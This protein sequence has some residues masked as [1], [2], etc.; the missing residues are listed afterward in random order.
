VAEAAIWEAGAPPLLLPPPP[1][2][3]PIPAAAPR[4]SGVYSAGPLQYLSAATA[5]ERAAALGL[6]DGAAAAEPFGFDMTSVGEG[7]DL[8]AL[9]AAVSRLAQEVQMRD[10]DDAH[11]LVLD[12]TFARGMF[13]SLWILVLFVSSDVVWL[14]NRAAI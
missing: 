9:R 14:L 5:G 8:A 4:S 1:R 3:L 10:V 2:V 11:R 6:R 12:A 7:C 13:D